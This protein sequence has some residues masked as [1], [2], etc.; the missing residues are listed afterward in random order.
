MPGLQADMIATALTMEG[1]TCLLECQGLRQLRRAEEPSPGLLAG[2]FLVAIYVAADQIEK[3]QGVVESVT[4]GQ[5]IKEQWVAD[6]DTGVGKRRAAFDAADERENVEAVAIGLETGAPETPAPRAEN[7]TL[8]L[9]GLLALAAT[10]LVVGS[11]C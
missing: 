2:T 8:R 5:L 3:A 7:T 6:R 11:Q 1:I 10:I 4:R 9:L